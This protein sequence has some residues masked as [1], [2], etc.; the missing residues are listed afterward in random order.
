MKI[1]QEEL[2][3]RLGDKGN[4]LNKL[5]VGLK[6]S[7]TPKQDFPE[8]LIPEVSRRG[9]DEFN[10]NDAGRKADMPNA[11]QSLRIVAGV[12]ARAEGN[13]VRVAENLNLSNGQVRY[14][15]KKIDKPTEK[16][17]QDIALTRLMDAIG[18]LDVDTIS[19]EK[20]KD[21][22][23]IAANLS[24]VH[25]NLR[26]KEDRGGNN[27]NIVMYA[28]RLRETKDYEVIEVQSATG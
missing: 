3:R 2:N 7:E 20:P 22:S 13:A 18:L 23:A 10:R 25:N 15:E 21:I 12:L 26:P 9:N 16:Q 14:A 28:P 27:V 5:N 24:R 1:T 19:G 4:L 11:P 6:I 17:V 8:K